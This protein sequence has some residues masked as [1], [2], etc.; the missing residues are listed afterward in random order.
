MYAYIHVHIFISLSLYV[1]YIYIH[2]ERERERGETKLTKEKGREGCKTD[3]Q[4]DTMD[5]DEAD[6]N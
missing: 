6:G 5:R 3:G 1:I 4:T 2:G